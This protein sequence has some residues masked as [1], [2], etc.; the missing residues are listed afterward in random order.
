MTSL[1]EA[2]LVAL[3]IALLIP[4]YGA[5]AERPDGRDGR[6]ADAPV[7]A[8]AAVAP[9]QREKDAAMRAL[10]VDARW[11]WAGF[12]VLGLALLHLKRLGVAPVVGTALA[13]GAWGAAGWLGRVPWPH[14]PEA[15]AVAS[16]VLLAASP[17]FSR[18]LPGTRS[19]AASAL[20]YPGF[21][22]ATGL[23]WLVLLDL[24]A[25]GLAANR[26]LA[27]YHHGHLWLAMLV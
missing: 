2:A 13:L 11:Q 19:T 17:W 22:A 7:T 14:A 18:F 26:Y 24:S 27:H 5:L 15:L 20:A 1:V 21:V 6:F 12:A 16:L 8:T 3:A 4:L 25:N 23:G 10:L 9:A